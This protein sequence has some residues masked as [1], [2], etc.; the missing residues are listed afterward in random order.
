VIRESPAWGGA[1]GAGGAGDNNNNS[2]NGLSNTP[3]TSTFY[4]ASFGDDSN[5]DA[6]NVF[7]GGEGGSDNLYQNPD[8]AVGD[9]E[10][11]TT[12][13]SSNDINNNDNDNDNNY[14]ENVFEEVFTQQQQQQQSHPQQQH[15]QQYAS[16]LTEA[17]L[18]STTTQPPRKIA[19]DETIKHPTT[20][21]SYTE[22]GGSDPNPTEP[23]PTTNSNRKSY[24]LS[25]KGLR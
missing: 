3:T 14:V 18:K 1:G 24:R 9:S 25:I 7:G 8:F 4:Q 13:N 15:Q 2:F 22:F 10:L 16:A 6:T 19:F 23:P 5:S 12:L 20:G 17:L 11:K 21:T